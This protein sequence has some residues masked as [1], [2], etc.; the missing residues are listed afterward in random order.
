MVAVRFLDC[1]RI[2]QGISARLDGELS[3]LDAVRL[4]THLEN[5]TGCR[6]FEASARF[7]ADMLRAA[8]LE[9]PNQPVAIPAR[10]RISLP[11]RVPA[12]AA[13]AV[14]MVAAGGIVASLHGGAGIRGS[15]A[16]Y[17][18]YNNHADMQALGLQQQQRNFQRL[19]VLR[20]QFEANRIVRHTGFQNP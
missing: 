4:K 19:L 13:A 15:H 12:A 7:A 14:V 5:C 2:R 8:P 18:A 3:E 6:E 9:Q 17:P 10:R 20:A 11:V 1:E 16:S